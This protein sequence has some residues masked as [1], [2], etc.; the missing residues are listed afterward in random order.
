MALMT[1]RV[2]D[3][4]LDLQVDIDQLNSTLGKIYPSNDDIGVSFLSL[5]PNKQLKQMF[6]P[7]NAKTNLLLLI[8]E[9]FT[10]ER[11]YIWEN[12]IKKKM[13]QSQQNDD[14][15]QRVGFLNRFLLYLLDKMCQANF[16]CCAMLRR[17]IEI[18]NVRKFAEEPVSRLNVNLFPNS[19][20]YLTQK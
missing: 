18:Q 13:L 1:G 17:N 7:Q 14:Q 6:T 8:E 9:E 16:S 19:L 12:F 15:I 10:F 5:F 3:Y 2:I 11:N 20:V 4:G